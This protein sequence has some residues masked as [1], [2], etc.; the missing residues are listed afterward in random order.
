MN[1]LKLDVKGKVTEFELLDDSDLRKGKLYFGEAEDDDIQYAIRIEIEIDDW[2]ALR[3][4]CSSSNPS[5]DDDCYGFSGDT[6]C[7]TI[8]RIAF[9]NLS[10]W[11]D[12]DYTYEEFRTQVLHMSQEDFDEYVDEL[13]S[14]F[15]EW[16]KATANT[17]EFDSYWELYCEYCWDMDSRNY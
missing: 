16:W 4:C 10:N 14:S 11:K 2:T 13:K 9:E 8:T 17:K 6:D 3:E 5:A 1:N 15:Y 12:V 7:V